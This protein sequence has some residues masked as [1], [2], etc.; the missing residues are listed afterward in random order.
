VQERPVQ[1]APLRPGPVE[2]GVH[3]RPTTRIEGQ[4]EG[5]GVVAE[6]VA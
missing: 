2:Q 6:D 1:V 5:S 3:V 4:P